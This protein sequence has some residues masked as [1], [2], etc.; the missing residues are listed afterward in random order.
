MAS[1]TQTNR[2]LSFTSPLGANT[3]LPMSVRGTEEISELFDFS[4]D[5]LAVPE[6]VIDPAALVGR[7]VT[8]SLQVT[9]TGM[10]RHFN[11]IVASFESTGGDSYFNSYRLRMVPMLWLL[12]LNRQTRVFQN[13]T[14]VDIVREVLSPY[15]IVPRVETQQS[16][17]TLEYCT[18]YRE[19]DLDFVARILQHHGIFY[20]FTHTA[21]D[22]TVVLSDAASHLS[23]CPVVSQFRYETNVEEQQSFYEPIIYGFSSCSTLITGEHASWDYRFMPYALSHASPQTAR[24]STPMGQNS[25]EAYDYADSASALLKTE[26]GDGKTQKLQ[27]SFQ[28]V[29]KEIAE[30]QSIQ[31]SGTSTASTMQAGFAF[32]LSDYPQT[33]KNIKYLIT[34]V[35]HSVE[36]RPGY[37]SE[38]S[39]PSSG[40]PYTNT[41]LARPFTQP[42]RKERTLQKP[43]VNGVVTG[44]VVTPAADDSYMDKYGR[45]C[46]QFWW[47][48]NRPPNTPDNTLLRVAQQWAGKG[49]GTYF[50]PRIGDEVLID[51]LDGDPDAPIVVGSVYNGVNMP[52]YD[53]QSEYTL[54][55]IL[56]RSSKGGGAANA[57][58]LRFND[59]M[60][61]EQIFVNAERDF[62][63]HVEH[64][65]HTLVGN[66][67]HRRIT[68]SQ[69]HSVGGDAQLTV[70]QNRTVVVDGD[71]AASVRGNHVESIGGS[72]SVTATAS[73]VHTSGIAHIIQ[74][75]EEVHI[76]GQTRVIIEGGIG[77]ICLKGPLGAISLDMTGITLEGPL[78]FGAADCLPPAPQPTLPDTQEIIAPQ[79]PGDTPEGNA[80]K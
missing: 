36:Q 48:R 27:A 28:N 78:R 29:T 37:R 51:F 71:A 42:W 50:W 62:D 33:E 21:S 9:D 67:E 32:T 49:W 63:L 15:S 57:N 11:G 7:R 5:L 60:G 56:T 13:K 46:V 44:K 8:L 73:Q 75:G 61:S 1:Y 55:G 19:T 76:S 79:W 34:R 30:A 72:H 22:H 23:D 41:F 66:E 14:V 43:R 47:D 6:T 18:Q 52:K 25:H 54:S 39:S 58:E 16:Y 24:S 2:I 59:K 4:L 80:S 68:S 26:S 53:P 31:C 74:A 45:V 3:L 17:V 38:V 77:G 40:Q 64:D 10:L 65:W 12:S 20:Y 69:Y 70:A 35:E